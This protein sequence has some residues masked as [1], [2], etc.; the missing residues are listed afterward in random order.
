M[1]QP[2]EKLAVFMRPGA[3]GCELVVLGTQPADWDTED[4]PTR[5]SSID[6]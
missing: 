1:H 3:F 6:Y 2:T 5:G 4:V